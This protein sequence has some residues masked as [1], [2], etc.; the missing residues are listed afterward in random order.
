MKRLSDIALGLVVL[1]LSLIVV[2]GGVSIFGV[3]SV[4]GFG[5]RLALSLALLVFR[6]RLSGVAARRQWYGYFALLL[7]LL[8]LLHF[9]GYRLR[10]DGM[11]YY[12]YARSLAFDRDLDFTNDYRGLGIDRFRGSQPVRE[13]GLPRNTF[14][15]GVG[16]LWIPFLILGHLGAGLRN[17]YG[18]ATAYDGFSDPYLHAVALGSMAMGWAGLLVLD[19]LLGRWFSPS[20]AFVASVGVVAG[21]F[22]LWYVAYQPVYTH[23]PGFLLTTLLIERWVRGPK[24]SRD[25]AVLGLLAGISACVRWQNAILL[26]LPLWSLVGILFEDRR[27][28]A[29]PV[30]AL[31]GGFLI[32]IIPQLVAWKVIF[33]RFLLG[34]PLGGDYM[35]WTSPFLE[36]LFF[37][38]R[39]GLFSW[40]PLLLFA[41]V[42]FLFFVRRQPG[43]GVPLLALVVGITYVNGSVA[44]W[45]AGGSFGARR[46]DSAIP[47]LSL[48]LATAAQALVGLVRRRPAVVLGMLLFLSVSVNLLFM[49]QYRKGRIPV[50]DTFSWEVA[51]RG[52]LEDFFDGVGYPFSFPANWAF[53]LRYERPKTQYDLLVGKYL[54]HWLGDLGGMIDLGERD[55]P[56][57]GNGWSQVRDWDE[58]P[59]EVRLAIGERAGI[60]VPIDRAEPLRIVVDCAAPRGSEP[61]WIEV[62]LNGG[63]LGR[64]RPG[65]EMSERSLTAEEHWW[66]RINLLEFA[67]GEQS[68]EPFL[69]VDRVRFERVGEEN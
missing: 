37:S 59:R 2:S 52:M 7:L 66:Q 53:A 15:V 54:F 40:S 65:R 44:D 35:R 45:W 21:S 17:A 6:Y 28:A 14:P 43:V 31:A 22:L 42:G 24:S 4:G 48:G 68:G 64:F 5:L 55:P 57:L 1:D 32:G 46:F 34:V 58:R 62:W 25:F 23:A 36:E 69:A 51:Y 8:P 3:V 11:W 30:G 18:L 9:R 50:D 61:R 12:A 41:A 47:I 16:L 39:H 26:F 29:R 67:A 63:R 56:F 10:G 13:T 20:I 38:S 27:D 60:F 49:E 33:D 19:R